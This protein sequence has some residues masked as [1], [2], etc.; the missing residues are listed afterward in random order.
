MKKK[1]IIGVNY[2]HNH[3]MQEERYLDKNHV[4]IDRN[5][6]KEVVDYFR[7]NPTEILK[8]GN[9]VCPNCTTEMTKHKIIDNEKTKEPTTTYQC[10]CIEC[11]HITNKTNA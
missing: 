8:L 2:L 10:A 7:A 11:G 9:S 4:I 6:W 5:E 1:K 3:P